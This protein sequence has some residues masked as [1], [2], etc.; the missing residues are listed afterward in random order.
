MRKDAPD[1][2]PAQVRYLGRSNRRHT[3]GNIYDAYFLEYWEG[4]RSSLHVRCNDGWI[5]DFIP[6]GDFEVV[7]DPDQVLN[8]FEA[9]VRCI[10]HTYDDDLF[11]VHYGKEYKAIAADKD[12]YYLVMDESYNCYF[13]GPSWFEVVSDV[14]GVLQHQSVYYSYN[15]LS[16][17][18]APVAKQERD[19]GQG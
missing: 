18:R 8:T 6:F 11:G 19:S 1:C 7:S 2:R 13:Y 16:D 14:H 9:V 12:G 4:E 17:P 15:N 3:R 10:K 5:R